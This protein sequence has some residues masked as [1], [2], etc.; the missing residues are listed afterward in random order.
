LVLVGAYALVA[1]VYRQQHCVLVFGHWLSVERTT[2]P[3]F[4]Q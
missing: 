2:I 4:C 3:L 1:H